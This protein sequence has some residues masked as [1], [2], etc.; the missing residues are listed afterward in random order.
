MPDP[1]PIEDNMRAREWH[2]ANV[3]WATLTDLE[4][5]MNQ[6][7][8]LVHHCDVQWAPV[9]EKREVEKLVVD[10]EIVV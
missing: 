4:E 1:C 10:R 3:C 9:L 8:C 5:L 6:D 2:A 7:T